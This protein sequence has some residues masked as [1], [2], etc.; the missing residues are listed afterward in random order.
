M[1]FNENDVNGSGKYGPN[2]SSL[3]VAF[4]EQLKLGVSNGDLDSLGYV[5]L[6]L[7]EVGELE[8]ACLTEE[9]DKV[10]SDLRGYSIREYRCLLDNLSSYA[11]FL[12][13]ENLGKEV[14]NILSWF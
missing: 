9:W 2:A 10:P 4:V 7:V 6:G 5:L 14:R 12:Y 11:S 1:V 8:E 3:E 13:G